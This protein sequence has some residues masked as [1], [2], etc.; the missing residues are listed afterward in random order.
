MNM[1]CRSNRWHVCPLSLRVLHHEAVNS[2]RRPNGQRRTGG[3]RGPSLAILNWTRQLAFGR[4]RVAGTFVARAEMRVGVAVT[5]P[6]S[7]YIIDLLP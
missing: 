3:Y 2:R 1:S 5:R 6:S 4:R 7:F